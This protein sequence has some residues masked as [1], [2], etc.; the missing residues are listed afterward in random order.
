MSA[1]ARCTDCGWI[2]HHTRP[3]DARAAADR[4]RCKPPDGAA[5]QRPDVS[6]QP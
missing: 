3:D 4:H 1:R 6:R 2:V 5:Q